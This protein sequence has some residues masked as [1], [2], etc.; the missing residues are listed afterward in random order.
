MLV[1]TIGA[2]LVLGAACT[3]SGGGKAKIRDDLTVDEAKAQLTKMV[4]DTA[5]AA[6]PGR[7]HQVFED[8]GPTGCEDADVA[9]HVFS[10][11]SVDVMVEDGRDPAQLLPAVEAHWKERGYT[12]DRHRLD[13]PEPELISRTEGFAMTALAVP[14]SGRLN[15]GG[16][17]PCVPN[18]E[19]DQEGPTPVPG[20]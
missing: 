1:L 20:G 2:L 16:D 19:R 7:P 13:D 18:P 12:I 6:A 4:L 10:T 11:W 17:T 15:I 14:G 9:R 3:S 8:I 5:A